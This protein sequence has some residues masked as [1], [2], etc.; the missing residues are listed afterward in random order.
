MYVRTTLD[1]PSALI[2][3]VGALSLLVPQSCG[4]PTGA[5]V[6]SNPEIC[7]TLTP[8]HGAIPQ[9]S[10]SPFTITPTVESYVPGGNVPCK[11]NN[12]NAW[13]KKELT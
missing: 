10:P 6:D 1:V 13:P 11:Y 5:P 9:T 4:Y 7:S 3:I 12:P 8:G 2:L